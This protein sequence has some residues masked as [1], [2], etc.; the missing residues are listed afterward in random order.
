LTTRLVRGG[1]AVGID[2]L[3]HLIIA[4]PEWISLRTTHPGIF[5]QLT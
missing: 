2:V 5:A 3:D 4:G 1:R